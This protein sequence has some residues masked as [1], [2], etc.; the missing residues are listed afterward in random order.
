VKIVGQYVLRAVVRRQPQ[1]VRGAGISVFLAITVMLAVLAPPTHAATSAS[2]Q[3]EPTTAQIQEELKDVQQQ[4]DNMESYFELLMVPVTILVGLL[5]AGGALGLVT[6]FRAERRQG[7]LHRLGVAGE[8]ASQERAGMSHLAFL[9]GSQETLTLVNDTLLLAKQAS[10]RAAEA[11]EEKAN[12]RIHDLDHEV[13]ELLSEAHDAHDFKAIVRDPY[14]REKIT[15]IAHSLWGIEGYAGLHGLKLTPHCHFARAFERHLGSA[16]KRAIESWREAAAG[17]DDPDLSAL[18]LFW[19]GYESNNVGE[20]KRAAESFCQARDRYMTDKNRAQHYGLSRIEIQTRFFDRASEQIAVDD[21]RPSIQE[22]VDDLEELMKPLNETRR[23]FAD[24]RRHYEE[25]LGE[26]WLWSARLSPQER[27]SS[28]PL[29]DIDR[30]CLDQAV[31]HF[32]R[33]GDHLWARF[34][35]AQAAWARGNSVA[36]DKYES[37]LRELIA[38]ADSH[39]EPRTIALR[40][41]AVLIAEAEHRDS[42][43]ALDRAHRNLWEAIG[44]IS[45]GL[46]VFSPW[47]K[48]N[49]A[50]EVFKKEVELFYDRTRAQSSP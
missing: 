44:H 29:S 43:E 47:Q 12:E 6:S 11:V 26:L 19:T 41:A 39:R 4:N 1:V 45:P 9:T 40:Q 24:E 16:P 30:E 46:T 42:R 8:T 10:E 50:L 34:G 48:R 2:T 5:A 17:H 15:D 36:E 7:E 31:A 37:L 3:G 38:E 22:F 21:R 32:D 13:R 14:L 33:G 35:R 18:A 25:T 20:F 28:E 49:V 27:T 23:E